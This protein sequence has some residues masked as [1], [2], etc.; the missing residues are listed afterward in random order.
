MAKPGRLV[1]LAVTHRYRRIHC[2]W[3]DQFQIAEY[4]RLV[5]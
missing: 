3:P 4:L 1:L 5:R 2:L